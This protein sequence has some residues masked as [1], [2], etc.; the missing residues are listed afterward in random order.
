MKMKT[1]STLHDMQKQFSSA[2][3]GTETPVLEN[4][5]T[6]SAFTSKQR[7]NIY[8]NNVLISLRNALKA[9]YPVVNKLVG[10]E[11]FNAMSRDFVIRHPSRS[12]NLH[13]FGEQLPAFING[14]APAGDLAYLSD[15][16]RLE[17]AYH[18]VFHAAESQPFNLEKLQQINTANYGNLKF[19]LNPA[20][21]LVS[22]PYPVL[23]IW[24][25]NQESS[26]DE[27][28]SL[29]EGQTYVLVFRNHMDIEFQLLNRAEYSFLS[30]LD[31][32]EK[33]FTA[34]DAATKFDSHCDVG[35]ILQKHILSRTI[36][37]FELKND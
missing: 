11:F 37:G 2:V 35:Q 26:D 24:E 5:I 9:V 27:S 15:V 28:V 13:D 22:S 29:D 23:R 33:F 32:H 19:I 17:W 34:C 25:A 31:R 21:R 14:F 20:C 16:A 4:N 8:S 1:V 30:A 18:V 7:L 12:G 6:A 36:T 3:L 10:D